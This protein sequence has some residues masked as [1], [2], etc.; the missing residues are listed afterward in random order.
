MKIFENT[1][2]VIVKLISPHSLKKY[3]VEDWKTIRKFPEKSG[4]YFIFDREEELIYLGKSSNIKKRLRAHLSSSYIQVPK[5]DIISAA[6]I[7]MSKEIELKLAEALYLLKY[8][9]KYNLN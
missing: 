9:P 2:E 3:K 7:L 4:I 1:S 5:T 6:Y 8:K